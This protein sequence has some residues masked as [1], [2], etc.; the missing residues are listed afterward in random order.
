MVLLH[1]QLQDEAFQHVAPR[2]ASQHVALWDLILHAILQHATV[3][4]AASCVDSA[5]AKS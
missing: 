3:W 1:L 5:P 4:H 2:V